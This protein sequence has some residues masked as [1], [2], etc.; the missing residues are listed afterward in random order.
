VLD[1]RRRFQGIIAGAMLV[2]VML[3]GFIPDPF[4]TPSPDIQHAAAATSVFEQFQRFF[5]RVRELFKTKMNYA[6]S[7]PLLR[8]IVEYELGA[9]SSPKVYIGRNNHLFYNGDFAAGQSAGDIYRRFETLR[10]VDMAAIL[11]RELERRGATLIVTVPP[12]A[13]SI[14]I[15]DLPSWS[16]P[17]PPFEYDLAISELQKRGVAAVDLKTPLLAMEDSNALYRL[18][19]PHWSMRGAVLGFN[20]VVS[21]GGH[22]E[23]VVEPETVLGQRTPVPAG[24]LARFMGIQNYLT[25]V[26]A[27]MLPAS[28]F[29]WEKL[30]ILRSPPFGDVFDPYVYSR[31]GAES[32]ERVLV[33]GDS[34]TQQYWLPLF[35]RSDVASIG[36]MHH[37]IC[38]FDFSDVE[39]FE[40]TLVILAPTERLMPCSLASWPQGLP[41]E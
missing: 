7:A 4:V 3:G 37:A 23:W 25:D 17:H 1:Q 34:F 41:R 20:L 28:E 14:A 2:I 32:G 38:N 16:K 27:T 21:G 35:K 15:D 39:H 19:D 22:P 36:W 12:N 31:K 9:S 6:A 40:P 10:F 11:R 5:K 26:D 30:D 13:Q 8:G 29:G 33:L 18:T 24:G